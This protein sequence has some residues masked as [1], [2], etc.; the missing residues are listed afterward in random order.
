MKICFSQLYV[1]V[2]WYFLFLYCSLGQRHSRGKSMWNC[3][4]PCF[5]VMH[6]QY[7]H[8]EWRII[9]QDPTAQPSLSCPAV[10]TLPPNPLAACMR[11]RSLLLSSPHYHSLVTLHLQSHVKWSDTQPCVFQ[12]LTDVRSPPLLHVPLVLLVDVP[13]NS[14]PSFSEQAWVPI[15]MT[16]CLMTVSCGR[17][18]VRTLSCPESGT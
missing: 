16:G 17:W 7:A 2:H 8:S 14:E 11:A 9:H 18:E 12:S 15:L 6:T 10:T 1:V 13:T 4:E 3:E 5:T